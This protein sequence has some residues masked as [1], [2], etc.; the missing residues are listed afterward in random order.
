[1]EKFGK[2]IGHAL[3]RC[4]FGDQLLAIY[5]RRTREDTRPFLAHWRAA[6][7]QELCTNSRG[8][9]RHKYH[10]LSIPSNFP[11]MQVLDNYANPVCSGRVGRQ[12]GGP[13]RGNGEIN[14]A[15]IAGL[16]EQKFTEWGHH[17]TIIKRF[18]TLLWEAAVMRVLR[19]AALE[20]DEKEKEKRLKAGMEN[21]SMAGPLSSSRADA[22]GTPASLVR[23]YLNMTDEDRRR[24]AFANNGQGD[25]RTGTHEN[26]T[27]PL[28]VKIVGVRQHVSTDKLVEYSLVICPTQLVAITRSGIKGIHPEPSNGTT[29]LEDELADD[30]AGGPRK[31]KKKATPEPDTIMP[32]WLPASIIRHVHPGLVE[33]FEAAEEA[34]KKKKKKKKKGSVKGKGKATDDYSSEVDCSSAPA[35]VCPSPTPSSTKK[36]QNKANPSSATQ[37]LGRSG[38]SATVVDPWFIADQHYPAG[39]SLFL[40]SDALSAFFLFSQNPDDPAALDSGDNIQSEDEDLLAEDRPRDRFDILFDQVMGLSRSSRSGKSTTTRKKRLIQQSTHEVE[41]DSRSRSSTHTVKRKKTSHTSIP[42]LSVSAKRNRNSID[43]DPDVIELSDFDDYRQP[44]KTKPA[45]SQARR[46][47]RYY[48]EPS[49][50]QSSR[51]FLDNADAIIDLT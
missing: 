22:V 46:A 43:T 36:A 7:N 16:C 27:N 21:W 45:A 50:S 4:G 1:V 48:P 2:D 35:K 34:K 44:V 5:E 39:P 23:R 18:R 30:T 12:G 6:V 25:P 31:G 26:E 37:G 29:N 40:N 38:S 47:N 19:R 14:L 13:M 51:S 32:M 11:D 33:D 15:K 20:A 41:E 9:L 8:F 28:I 49:S 10:S 42:D 17:T 24:A 3:A